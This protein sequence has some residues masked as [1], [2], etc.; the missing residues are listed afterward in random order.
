MEK[1]VFTL[2]YD[3][4]TELTQS[5][6]PD[7]T[8]TVTDK[9]LLHRVSSVLRAKPGQRIIL[10]NRHSH[11]DCTIIKI[12]RVVQFSIES[13]TK[14]NDI[15]PAITCILPL[16]KRE[17]FEEAVYGLTEVGVQAIHMV[18]TEKTQRSWGG[19]KEMERTERVMRAAA[20][21]SKNFAFPHLV[22]LSS[23]AE[24][25]KKLPN[26]TAQRFFLDPAGRAFRDVAKMC[27][28]N[29]RDEYIIM[30]GPEGDLTSQ[31]KELLVHN[32][33]EKI[34][35]TP[36]ILRAQQAIVVAAGA[37]RSLLHIPKT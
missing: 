18:T 12:D 36:T 4:L 23:L 15:K 19:Q 28:S 6:A 16:L 17:A 26:S 35:L 31:E 27:V 5:C 1:H 25:V 21:Q 13:C 33:F 10:F 14:N 29:N 8:C 22:N 32:G 2:F 24:C 20:E 3:G 9:D 37:L 11:I 30:A 34:A 7:G